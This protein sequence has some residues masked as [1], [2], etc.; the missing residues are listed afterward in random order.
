MASN[1]GARYQKLVS[2]KITRFGMPLTVIRGT[3]LV[4]T[5]QQTLQGIPQLDKLALAALVEEGSLNTANDQPHI[6]VFPGGSD[7]QE[8]IDRVLYLGWKYKVT[9]AVPM[10]VSGIAVSLHCYAIR[11]GQISS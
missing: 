3:A 7:V 5:S 11:D 1:T 4:T 10:M 6:F 9:R 2:Q 8:I